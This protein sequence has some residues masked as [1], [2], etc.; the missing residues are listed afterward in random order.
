MKS[1][2]SKVLVVLLRDAVALEARRA[3]LIARYE[4]I[5][6]EAEITNANAAQVDALE[7]LCHDVAFYSTNPEALREDSALFADEE[8]LR[9]IGVVLR[10]FEHGDN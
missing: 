4:D 5:V 1:V 10:M 8:L 7:D 6:G 3:E 2:D 9:R